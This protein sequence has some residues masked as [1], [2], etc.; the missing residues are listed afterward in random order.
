MARNTQTV[1]VP[2]EQREG[3]RGT[4]EEEVEDGHPGGGRPTDSRVE[5]TG[6]PRDETGGARMDQMEGRAREETGGTQATAMKA[7]LYGA[8]G[9]RSHGGGG[10][11]GVVR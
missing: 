11:I 4:Q 5:T 8:N 3:W 1:L 10:L 7:T 9:G 6:G 2:Q